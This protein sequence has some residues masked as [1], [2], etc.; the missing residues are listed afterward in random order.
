MTTKE[1]TFSRGELRLIGQGA[2]AE[3]FE[4]GDGRVLKLLRSR[5][6]ADRVA[7]EVAALEARSAGLQVPQAYEQVV[8]DGR[9]GIVMRSW[10]HCDVASLRCR[11]NGL[12]VSSHTCRMVRRFAMATSTLDS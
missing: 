4:R 2:E 12:D 9:P 7:Y 1:Q 5:G 10:R 6:S 3:V 11:W 8:V